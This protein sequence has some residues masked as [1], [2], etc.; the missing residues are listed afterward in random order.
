MVKTMMK[1]LML[2]SAVSALFVGGWVVI[3]L[4]N[5]TQAETVSTHEGASDFED[6]GVKDVSGS[7]PTFIIDKEASQN[8]FIIRANVDGSRITN[9]H[10]FTRALAR[11]LDDVR[12]THKIISV[13]PITTTDW[14]GSGRLVTLTESLIVLVE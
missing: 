8:V 3:S 5:K 14:G 7:G 9:R 13:T 11:G 4:A 12:K 10:V 6:Y 2:L 1:C